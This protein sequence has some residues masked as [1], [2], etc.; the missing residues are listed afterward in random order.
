MDKSHE[1]GTAK[2]W[3][4][5]LQEEFTKESDRAAVILVASLFDNAL[6]TFLKNVLLPTPAAA[7]ELFDL[8]NAP[9]AT[10]SAKINL[11]YR[12]G[13]ISQR[14]C[15]DL[16]LIRKIRNEFAHNIYGCSFETSIVRSRI[17]EL[18]KSSGM[19]ERSPRTRGYSQFPEGCRGDFLFIASWMLYSLNQ[20]IESCQSL[21]E[22]TLE[23]GYNSKFTEETKKPETAGQP[24]VP[25]A[26]LPDNNRQ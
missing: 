9:L 21:P 2:H 14:F 1:Y 8:P 6:T 17:L 10:F 16:H 25:P 23:W 22:A 15:R 3:D 13:V 26:S 4:D 19:I 11:S 20:Q 18:S 7:D 24:R 5:V 12:I